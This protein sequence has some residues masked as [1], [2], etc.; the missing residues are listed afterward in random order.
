[1]QKTVGMFVGAALLVLATGIAHAYDTT[2]KR[3]QCDTYSLHGLGERYVFGGDAGWI[4]NNVWDSSSTEGLDCS[5]Y[6][7]RCWAT[8]GPSD[9]YL[10]EHV[11]SN[12][13]Y[14]T[15]DYYP[16][17][18][19][20][21]V[22]VSLSTI[23][24]WDCFVYDADSTGCGPGN[25]MALIKAWDASNIFTR[26][27]RGTAYGIVE[28]TRSKQSLTDACSRYYRRA[29]W[30][31]ES[32]TSIIVDNTSAGFSVTGTW[33]SGTGSTDK[34]GTDYRYRSTAPISEPAVWSTSLPSTK[35]YGVY[36]WWPQGSNRST[37]AAYIISTSAGT[38]T[39]P[40]NQQIN[41]GK[42]NLLG[43]FNMNAGANNVKLS[44]WTTTGFVVVADA[45]KWQ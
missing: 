27:A 38:T 3:S 14:S 4:D 26:E 23:Q 45:V 16:G 43:T 30:G 44:C 5:S 31:A 2:W 25:H 37:T 11:A 9:S 21:T 7:P 15:Y 32:G 29:N 20:H 6:V 42:W 1:M 35:S 34:Y 22:Q 33:A 17:L 41:G 28:V 10:G 40:V 24:Q 39:V 18:V 12:H 8:D 36:A 19:P 13:P